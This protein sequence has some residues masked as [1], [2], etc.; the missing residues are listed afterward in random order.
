[1]IHLLSYEV[2]VDYVVT[3]SINVDGTNSAARVSKL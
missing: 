3:F 2:Y 1:M